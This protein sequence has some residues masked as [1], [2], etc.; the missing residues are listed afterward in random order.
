MSSPPLDVLYED[1]W[2]IAI[3]KEAG[4]LV[5]AADHPQP[6]DI[7]VMKLVRDLVGL[8]IYPTHRLDRPTCGVVVF[9]KGRTAARALNRSF[10]RKQVKKAYLAIVVGHPKLD[11]WTCS[12]PLRKGEDAPLKEASTRFLVLQLLSNNLT[13]LEAHPL[14]GRYH[15]IRKHL[16]H[17][18]HPIVGDYFYHG[19][20]PCEAM[21]PQLGIGT[22]MLLQCHR[23]QFAH[24]IT[25]EETVITAQT[26]SHIARLSQS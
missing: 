16:L 24:P 2:I 15:Q 3:N 23:L 25:K 26:E 1:E 7:V 17:C 10:E 11:S 14:T 22:R 5:H 9:A 20:E 21:G 8:K 18:G 12:E 19:F 6:D 4:H 13:L